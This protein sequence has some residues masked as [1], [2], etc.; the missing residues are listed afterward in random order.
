MRRTRQRLT[1][2]AL[3]IVTVGVVAPGVATGQ[4]PG[5][6][7][8]VGTGEPGGPVTVD[9][10]AAAIAAE[11]WFAD[12]ASDVDTEQLGPL[13]SRLSIGTDP[14]GFAVLATEPEGSSPAFAERVLDALPAQGERSIETVAVLSPND[15]GVV[16]DAWDDRAIDDALDESIDA[17]RADPVEGLAA[18]GSALDDQAT[19]AED[20]QDGGGPN[21]GLVVLGVVGVGGLIAASRLFPRSGGYDDG[22]SWGSS[23]SRRRRWSRPSSFG[24]SFGRSRSSGGG[25]GR[26]SSGGR[27]RGRGGRR[28]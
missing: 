17:L 21:T 24:R 27:S 11:G 18:L 22:D 23:Y 4:E 9:A 8:T 1:I 14:I 6:T 3:A 10:V 28:L 26:R 5:S 20:D 7:T 16:S 13:A 25:G 15:V 2:A 19:Q 12:P